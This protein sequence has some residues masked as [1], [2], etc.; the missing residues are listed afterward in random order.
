[1][2][3]LQI[4]KNLS[5]NRISNPKK[6]QPKNNLKHGTSKPF[7]IKA[8]YRLIPSL[9]LLKESLM[10]ALLAHHRLRSNRENQASQDSH[11]KN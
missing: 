11:R 6:D 8:K 2:R 5:I 7:L 1:M 10:I 3:K 9:F 4:D